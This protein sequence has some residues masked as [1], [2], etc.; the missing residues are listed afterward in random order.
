VKLAGGDHRRT[1]APDQGA[2]THRRRLAYADRCAN[3]FAEA[4]RETLGEA[5]A[6]T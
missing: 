5:E 4:F 6:S 3:A 1:S 2:L